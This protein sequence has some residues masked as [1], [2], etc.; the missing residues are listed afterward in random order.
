M[1]TA[2][3]RSVRER[4]AGVKWNSP[5]AKLCCIFRLLGLI[6]SEVFPF[7]DKS[8]VESGGEGEG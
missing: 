1:G 6:E 7:S 5:R 4:G 3:P 2:Q 8:W